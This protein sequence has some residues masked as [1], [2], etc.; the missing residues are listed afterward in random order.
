MPQIIALGDSITRWAN[1]YEK[2]WRTNRLQEKFNNLCIYTEVYN[3][4][5][6]GNTT[7]DLLKRFETEISARISEDEETFIIFA[8]GINDTLIE[9]ETGNN[10]VPLKQFQENI[11]YLIKGAKY[12]SENI[13][14]LE[15]TNVIEELTHPIERAPMYSYENATIA[16][17]NQAIAEIC[18]KEKITFIELPTTKTINS[19]IPFLLPEEISDGVHPNEKWHQKIA[20]I[21]FKALSPQII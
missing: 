7:Q 9:N 17:Y 16:T 21:V 18:K 19:S 3:C 11:Q 1:D 12:F 5:I 15:I 4:W 13:H 2:F 8:I 10:K 6:S 14:I 20:D